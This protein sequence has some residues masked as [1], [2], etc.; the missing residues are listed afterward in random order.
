M[1]LIIDNT[2][3]MITQCKT[4]Q[5]RVRAPLKAMLHSAP[6]PANTKCSTNMSA[7]SSAI[8]APNCSA[9]CSFIVRALAARG[10]RLLQAGRSGAHCMHVCS[11]LTPNRSG[12]PCGTCAQ[13][14]TGPATSAAP[15]LCS[16]F[17]CGLSILTDRTR[18][19]TRFT[20]PAYRTKTPIS[21]LT[22]AHTSRCTSR[23]VAFGS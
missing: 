3:W 18:R 22:I 21:R 1:G 19:H 6:A 11:L 9:A 14:F 2:F 16:P 10:P 8:T 7:A 17:L 15:R 12:E 5:H 23:T 13:A 20:D 4:K